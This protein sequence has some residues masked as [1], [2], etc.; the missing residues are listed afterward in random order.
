MAPLHFRQHVEALQHPVRFRDQRFADVKARKRL[1]LEELDTIPLLCDQRGHGRTRRAT[2]DHHNIRAS[3]IHM[4]CS[5][6]TAYHEI[7]KNTKAREEFLVQ[8]RFV[9]LRGLRDD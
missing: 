7:T 4:K 1:T 9:S 6:L 5:K 2:A 8:E 3:G